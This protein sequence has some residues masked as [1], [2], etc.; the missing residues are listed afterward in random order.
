LTAAPAV[1]S[2]GGPSLLTMLIAPGLVLTFSTRRL[3]F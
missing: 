3:L 1:L 2:D